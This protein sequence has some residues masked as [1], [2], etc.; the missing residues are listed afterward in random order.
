MLVLKSSAFDNG[1]LIPRMHTCDGKNVSPPFFWTGAP[2]RTATFALIADD[3]DAPRKTFVH[4]VLFDVPGTATSLPP[5][6]PPKPLL[7][8]GAAQGTNDFG[9][10]GYGGPCPPSGTHNYVF[11][12]YALDAKLK[13]RGR[14]SKQD[15]LDAMHGHIL[16]EARLVGRYSRK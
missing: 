16:G 9:D 11:T 13:P 10:V 15:L 5:G 1:G 6:V 12:L 7:E 3:P 8:Q 4:W 2:E 14:M